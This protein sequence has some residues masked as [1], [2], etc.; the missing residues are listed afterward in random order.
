M[1]PMRRWNIAAGNFFFR[2]RNALFP[3]C[4]VLMPL[5]GRPTMVGGPWLDRSLTVFGMLVALL[6]QLMRLVTIGY[7]YIERGGRQGKVYASHLVQGGVYALTRNPMYVGNALIAVG[8]TMVAGAPQIYL[9][10]L[11]FFLFIYQAIVAAEEVY[12]RGQFGTAYEQYC[13]AVNRW[14]PSLRQIPKALGG[15]RYDWRSAVRKELSTATGLLTGFVLLPVWRTFFLEGIAAAKAQLPR[16]L[17][18]EL[19][20]LSLYGA[21][22]YL[23][24]Q[25]RFF[26][27]SPHQQG[28][29]VK[30]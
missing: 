3:A 25:R 19:V 7:E 1:N 24:Q 13:A 21:L 5:I 17:L 2:Y 20:V 9:G 26:Y 30:P 29:T 15:R 23:K 12:L 28:T 14:W 6:G 8:M 16:A 11:P 10:V 27:I 22:V 18:L 4:F